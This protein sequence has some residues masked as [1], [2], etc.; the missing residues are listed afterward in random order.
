VNENYVYI[1]FH[2]YMLGDEET[3]DA[4]FAKESDA[5]EYMDKQ[6]RLPFTG[7]LWTTPHQVR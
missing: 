5:K 7:H 1:V 2:R 6:R 3:V 4:V